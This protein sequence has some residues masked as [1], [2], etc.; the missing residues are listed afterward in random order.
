MYSNNVILEARKAGV[1]CGILLGRIRSTKACI[2]MLYSTHTNC[3]VG[4]MLVHSLEHIVPNNMLITVDADTSFPFWYKLEYE[5][6]H[7][8][9]VITKYGRRSQSTLDRSRCDMFKINQHS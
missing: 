5:P 3:G 7:G 9:S 1:L 8:K 2:T 4:T 6:V